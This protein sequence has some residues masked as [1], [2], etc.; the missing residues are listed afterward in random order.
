MSQ[1]Q[2]YDI[3]KKATAKPCCRALEAAG[4][5]DEGKVEG[6]GEGWMDGWRD[7]ERMEERQ[8]ERR[9]RN[10]KRSRVFFFPRYMFSKERKIKP[11]VC[12]VPGI[13]ADEE[14]CES[15]ACDVHKQ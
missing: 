4:L 15:A 14:H 7:T 11:S 2:R 10:K 13:C 3:V 5:G 1:K 6:G 9:C 12:G 8:R